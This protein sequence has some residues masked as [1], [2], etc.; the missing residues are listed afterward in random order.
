MRIMSARWTNLNPMGKNCMYIGLFVSMV[1]LLCVNLILIFFVI[2][3]LCVL[4]CRLTSA[5]IR[6]MSARFAAKLEVAQTEARNAQATVTAL[7]A[8]MSSLREENAA[9]KDTVASM[10][11]RCIF[12]QIF[13]VAPF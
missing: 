7:G 2:T 10:V 9:L 1:I 12:L 5:Q 8:T 4:H 3:N 11:C 6:E 13:V